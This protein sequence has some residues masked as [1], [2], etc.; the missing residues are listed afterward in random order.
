MDIKSSVCLITG[1]SSRLG[2]KI[3]KSLADMGTRVIIHYNTG[4]EAA[5]KLQKTIPESAVIQFDLLKTELI[6]QFYKKAC[7]FFGPPNILINNASLFL[8]EKDE[9]MMRLHLEAPESLINCFS[10]NPGKGCIINITDASVSP[11]TVN[12][13]GYY[14][15]KKAL[16]ELTKASAL[17]LAPFIRVNEIAPGYVLKAQDGKQFEKMKQIIPLKKTGTADDIIKAV[18]YLIVADYVTGQKMF[19]DGGLNLIN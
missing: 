15:S 7:S 16:S 5:E 13:R 4:K 10:K 12:Y 8:K 17:R 1:S 6:T 9:D 18:K 2:A 11:E 3:A 14:N 19:V